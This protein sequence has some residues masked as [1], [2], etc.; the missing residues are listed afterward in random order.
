[1]LCLRSDVL[2]ETGRIAIDYVQ[3]FVISLLST[4]LERL[5]RNTTLG[6][7][8]EKVCNHLLSSLKCSLLRQ[9]LAVFLIDKANES[10]NKQYP[11]GVFPEEL[12]QEMR[13][14]VDGCKAADPK[15]P[16][17]FERLVTV[18]FGFDWL[19]V[20]AYKGAVKAYFA[21]LSDLL[22]QEA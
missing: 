9:I 5:V 17:T 16:V 6:Q 4:D 7:D 18:N 3:R 22:L 14:I 15:C 8:L 20:H 21:A 10:W 12:V 2:Q 13:G 11:E 19:S 1:M